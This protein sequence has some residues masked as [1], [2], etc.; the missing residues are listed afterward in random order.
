VGSRGYEKEGI[1][2]RTY[3]C[4]ADSILQL[5]RPRRDSGSPADGE[6]APKDMEVPCYGHRPQPSTRL[7]IT[8]RFTNE[9]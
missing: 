8:A 3:E 2:H 6:P 4:N 5:D 1:K 7:M 9:K